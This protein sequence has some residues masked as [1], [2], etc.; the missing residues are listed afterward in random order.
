MFLFCLLFGCLSPGNDQRAW[1]PIPVQGLFYEFA[2]Y[3]CWNVLITFSFCQDPCLA[4]N[5]GVHWIGTGALQSA[6]IWSPTSRL[7]NSSALEDH[8]EP[9]R[10]LGVCKFLAGQDGTHC[11]DPSFLLYVLCY[12]T[13]TFCHLALCSP[14]LLPGVFHCPPLFLSSPQKTLRKCLVPVSRCKIPKHDHHRA[15]PVSHVN[16]GVC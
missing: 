16:T 12:L 8:L 4:Q 14:E 11:L 9:P 3:F 1:W 13:R 2:S 5:P 7:R 6:Q 10:G 15:S